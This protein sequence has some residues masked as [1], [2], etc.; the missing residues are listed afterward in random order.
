MFPD[1]IS[2]RDQNKSLY[3]NLFFVILTGLI[4][5]VFYLYWTAALVPRWNTTA[6]WDVSRIM[7][8]FYEVPED[9]ISVFCIGSS[10]V[11]SGLSAG[12]LTYTHGIPS[13]SCATAGQTTFGSYYWLREA[14]RTQSPEVVI[15]DVDMLFHEEQFRDSGDYRKVLDYMKFSPVKAEAVKVMSEEISAK[16]TMSYFF[17]ILMYHDRWK[18][19]GTGDFR[20]I[21]SDK[22]D[23]N[24][25]FL[26]LNTVSE[27]APQGVVCTDET[28]PVPFAPSAY[29]YLEKI[30]DLCE[31]EGIRL[32]L[33]KTPYSGWTDGMSAAVAKKAS[34]W[35]IPF[36]DYNSVELMQEC[37]LADA[38][39]Y[40]D[41]D[42]LNLFGAERL[43]ADIAGRLTRDGL[44][45]KEPSTEKIKYF[46]G[47]R[48]DYFYNLETKQ[49]P[50]IPSDKK[51][52]IFSVLNKNKSHY[53]M[54]VLGCAESFAF[55]DDETK[56][57][58][59]ELG[60]E[61]AFQAVENEG[62]VGIS[63]GGIMRD[64]QSSPETIFLDGIFQDGTEFKLE[65]NGLNGG[66]YGKAVIG[67]TEKRFEEG[68]INFVV[69][70]NINH[71][72]VCV[73]TLY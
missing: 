19:M 8:G 6:E 7:Q 54:I 39:M 15:L 48:E 12:Q 33:I 16:E 62:Y 11:V 1:N 18:E 9:S 14:L 73:K 32:V 61:T 36:W 60:F 72:F 5:V 26:M 55:T 13:Y 4:L 46:D 17:P 25:G 58:I 22:T 3:R 71:E 57:W 70:D 65:V 43:T 52:D 38:K 63:E 47:L 56:K 30:A 35:N 42:H 10:H 67:E 29:E 45:Q 24:L 37:G 51:E 68:G 31:R 44:L 69:Y 27:K 2:E 41:A 28:E 64:T 23:E 40:A 50:F 20:E 21:F 34:E 49:L 53:T 66:G 59:S